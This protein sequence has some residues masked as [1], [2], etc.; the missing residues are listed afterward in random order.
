[1]DISTINGISLDGLDS[2]IK[3]TALTNNIQPEA[4]SD[5]LS[6]AM[7]ALDEN[8]T[9]QK[10]KESAEIQFALGEATNTHDLLIAQSKA[11]TAMQY[12]VAVRDKMLEAYREIM[13]ISI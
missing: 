7:N 12:T 10:A 2:Y 5:V 3:D 6:A 4:F 1:M 13:Q 11:L 8:N 9:L